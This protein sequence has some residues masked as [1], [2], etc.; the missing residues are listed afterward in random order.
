MLKRTS[1]VV[2]VLEDRRKSHSSQSDHRE[3][4]KVGRTVEREKKTFSVDF[5][6]KRFMGPTEP[7]TTSPSAGPHI[8]AT[9][10]LRVDESRTD[11]PDG[12][13]V[14]DR[15]TVTGH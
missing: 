5:F 12:G 2:V 11:S 15:W 6:Y 10:D 4:R 8:V 7:L 13:G 9:T 14:S 3:T 1:P